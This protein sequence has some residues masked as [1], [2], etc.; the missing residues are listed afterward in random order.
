VRYTLTGPDGSEYRSTVPGRLAGIVTTGVFGR[1]D[2]RSGM[3][4]RPEH[5]RFSATYEDA[6]GA[7]FRPC[8][9]CRP[10]L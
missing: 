3:R 7:G 1:L 8:Q 9:L 6:V 10:E 2:C 4:A 5:R